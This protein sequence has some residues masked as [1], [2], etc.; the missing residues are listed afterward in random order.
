MM[1]LL[2]KSS[3]RSQKPNMISMILF[4]RIFR[5]WVSTVTAFSI[6]SLFYKPAKDLIK[7]LLIKDPNERL[8][9]KKCL[10]HPWI[11]V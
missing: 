5:I 10:K 3:R 4:G 11:A 9:A 1:N 7:K 2:P 8:S 6:D